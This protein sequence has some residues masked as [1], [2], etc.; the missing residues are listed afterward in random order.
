MSDTEDLLRAQDWPRITAQL[1][2][3]AFKR[4]RQRSWEVAEEIAQQAIANAWERGEEG[5]NPKKEPLYKYLA[6]EVIGLSLNEW[7]RRRNRFEV[8][9]DDDRAEML[10]DTV[11]SDDAGADEQI[12]R[13]EYLE[14]FRARL[15][16][17]VAGNEA[18]SI[19][20]T[21]M[22]EGVDTPRDQAAASGLS[23][24]AIRNARRVVQYQGEIVAKELASEMEDEDERESE[25]AR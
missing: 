22:L 1:T 5:W 16:A 24:D 6:R 23:I 3:F 2:V 8:L 14:Q 4:T 11:A 25:V 19:V 18:A 12:A 10:A 17:R 9:V 7:R 13:R 21:L 20:V 15:T